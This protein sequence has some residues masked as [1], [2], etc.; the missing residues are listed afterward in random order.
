MAT[1]KHST[2][3]SAATPDQRDDTI[4]SAPGLQD[5]KLKEPRLLDVTNIDFKLPARPAALEIAGH[6]LAPDIDEGDHVIID[7]E[8]WPSPGEVAVFFF[9]SGGA[10][11]IKRLVM[12]PPRYFMRMAATSEVVGM[13][14]A[15]STNP[16]TQWQVR[17]DQLEAMYPVAG[18]VKKGSSAVVAPGALDNPKEARS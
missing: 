9:K 5:F 7:L 6:C 15:E 18:V 16:P 11:A 13:V 3:R 10:P 17:L 2:R 8:R 12:V 1:R 14:L 4:S